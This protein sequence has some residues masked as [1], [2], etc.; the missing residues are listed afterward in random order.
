MKIYQIRLGPRVESRMFGTEVL[1]FDETFMV[2][3]NTGLP[4]TFHTMLGTGAIV[5]NL[6]KYPKF[7]DPFDDV[8]AE[9]RHLPM[10][11]QWMENPK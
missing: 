8:L 4:P 10:L 2:S 3:R 7:K 6:C 9:P 1:R 11:F 5:R